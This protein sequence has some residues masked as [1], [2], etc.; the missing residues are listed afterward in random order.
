MFPGNLSKN[1]KL[2]SDE[3]TLPNL[4]NKQISQ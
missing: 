1:K 3:F 2:L 4:E